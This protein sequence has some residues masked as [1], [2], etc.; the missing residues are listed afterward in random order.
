MGPCTMRAVKKY[1]KTC[2]KCECDWRTACINYICNCQ[3]CSINTSLF[4]N[5]TSGADISDAKLCSEGYQKMCVAS[6]FSGYSNAFC[7]KRIF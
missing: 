1:Y 6:N 7:R 5:I 3:D 2:C 4:G